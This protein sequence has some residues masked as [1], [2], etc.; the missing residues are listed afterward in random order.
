MAMT[1]IA[2]KAGL[3]VAVLA[4]VGCAQPPKTLYGWGSYQNNLYEHF[5]ADGGDVSAQ[6]AALEA[7]ATANKAAA[8]ADPPG[9]H[10]HLALLYGKA[11]NDSAAQQQ[12]QVERSL[13]PESAAYV[14]FLLKKSKQP[15]LKTEAS[16][17]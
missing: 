6:I 4:L 11:G 2:L 13:F 17:G 9:L 5:K 16:N 12:L 15:A 8:K 14:D 1:S 10:G 7:Q 3:A